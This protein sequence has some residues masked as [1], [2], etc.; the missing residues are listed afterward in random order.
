MGKLVTTFMDVR[1][2]LVCYK[3]RSRSMYRHR[4]ENAGGQ[5]PGALVSLLKPAQAFVYNPSHVGDP[6]LSNNHLARHINANIRVK[7]RY[8]PGGP[9]AL[10]G[11][12]TNTLY[13]YIR[14]NGGLQDELL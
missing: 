4:F 2:I 13:T 10:S 12:D 9:S 8:N 7:F 3:K 14:Y 1:I 5:F 11:V 6:A